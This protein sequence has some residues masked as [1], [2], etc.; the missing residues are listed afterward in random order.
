LAPHVDAGVGLLLDGDVDVLDL[1]DRLVAVD[2]RIDQGVV[3]IE[4]RLL[5]A[6]VPGAGVAGNL[7]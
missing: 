4:H 1:L 6:L 7:P 3:E 5:P 2:R